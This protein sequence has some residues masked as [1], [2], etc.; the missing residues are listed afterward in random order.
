MWRHSRDTD[1]RPVRSI[2]FPG[3]ALLGAS[4][5][6]L[7]FALTDDPI[8]PR[9][10]GTSLML[11]VGAAAAF[12]AFVLRQAQARVP[13]VDLRHFRR[14]P[15]AAGFLT[16]GLVGAALI[17][18]MVNVPLFTNVVLGESAIRGGLNL[19]RLTVAVPVG[20]LAGGYFASR[21]G[22]SRT[23][24]IA[25]AL[26]GAG[27]LGM[28]RWDQTPGLLALTAP[29]LVAGLG[30]G[31]IIAPVNA[32]VLDE[33]PEGERATVSSLLTVVRLIGALVGVALLTTRG[34]GGFYAEAGLI[35]LD[36]PRYADLLRGLEVGAFRDTF[37]AT[38][39]L[40]FA[41]MLPAVLLGFR[42]S[43]GPPPAQGP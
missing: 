19:M 29:L 18:A 4:L 6:A 36:D 17:V 13:L 20:A 10:T 5:V 3:A 40:C 26:A 2:D 37:L 21:I 9:S 14:L 39:L 15:L 27:F 23:G 1:R 41:T 32:A 28:S 16:N 24:A 8:D 25:L 12:A 43:G 38:A 22:L 11:Y 7:T 33:V 35:P 31:L 30:L 34:L 42:R